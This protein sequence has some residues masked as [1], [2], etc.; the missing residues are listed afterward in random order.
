[1]ATEEEEEEEVLEVVDGS[2]ARE[3][4]TVVSADR[5]SNTSAKTMTE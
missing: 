2:T 5:E 4:V 1:V 3:W